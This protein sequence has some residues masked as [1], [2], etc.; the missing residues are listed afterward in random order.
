MSLT[1]PVPRPPSP[2][3]SPS[4]R[5]APIP[6]THG[7]RATLVVA[8]VMLLLIAIPYLLNRSVVGAAPVHLGQVVTLGTFRYHPAPGWQ[9]DRGASQADLVSVLVK[10][11]TRYR[12]TPLGRQ[13]SAASA[14]KAAARRYEATGRGR[15]GGD[16]ASVTTARGLTGL[17]APISGNTVAGTLTVLVGGG[18]GLGVSLTARHTAP[19]TEAIADDVVT[20]LD[21]VEVVE[22]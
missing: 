4:S 10:G 3:S 7:L 2:D 11:A 16:P 15:V 14:F 6:S 9:I 8:V 5:S 20:M 12:L 18:Q 19:L 17:V 1:A 21:S 22:S 13:S